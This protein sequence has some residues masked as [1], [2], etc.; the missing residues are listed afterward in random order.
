MDQ[1]I[2][3]WNISSRFNSR[4]GVHLVFHRYQFRIM[5]L[6]EG[7]TPAGFPSLWGTWKSRNTA[8][9]IFAQRLPIVRSALIIFLVRGQLLKF[10]DSFQKLLC[11]SAM[12]R[13]ISKCFALSS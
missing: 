7:V 5:A 2:A 11:A 13:I 8:G 4:V 9:P 3:C 6:N 1:C 10:M 12:Q